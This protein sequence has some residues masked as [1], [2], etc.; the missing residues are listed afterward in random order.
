M[1]K[2]F[3]FA[4]AKLFALLFAFP[5]FAQTPIHK[6]SAKS[7]T[8]EALD[9]EAFSPKP[10]DT[11]VAP[12]IIA[13]G[14][15]NKLT[16]PQ[17]MWQHVIANNPQLWVW[18]GDIIYADRAPSAYIYGEVQRPGQFRIERGM[19][20]MQA[21]ATNGGISARGTQRG[22]KVHRRDAQGN[23]T[24]SDIGMNDPVQRDDV[25]YVKE[26]LF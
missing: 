15:C 24:I 11:T 25:I 9:A 21:L 3:S 1:K 8:L 20:L 19:S 14:S 18:L 13:F 6:E 26:S 23:V 12:T 22:I 7:G 10:I 5:V 2:V 17:T 4:S 16:M